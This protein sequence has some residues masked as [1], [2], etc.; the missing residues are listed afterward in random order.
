MSLLQLNFQGKSWSRR[1]CNSYD[2]WSTTRALKHRPGLP[3]Y[4]SPGWSARVRALTAHGVLTA[5]PTLTLPLTVSSVPK[6]CSPH[7]RGRQREP[8]RSGDVPQ[9]T[10]H[11]KTLSLLAFVHK[12]DTVSHGRGRCQMAALSVRLHVTDADAPARQGSVHPSRHV[13]HEGGAG[14]SRRSWRSTAHRRGQYQRT[15]CSSAGRTT[16]VLAQGRRRLPVSDE[17]LATYLI[18]FCAAR[19]ANHLSCAAVLPYPCARAAHHASCHT[20]LS[21]ASLVPQIRPSLQVPRR[22]G[23]QTPRPSWP[24]PHVRA[25]VHRERHISVQPGR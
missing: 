20:L 12:V 1:D 19:Y 21:L 15:T 24:R 17:V 16:G 14:D 3:L 9:L 11:P 2:G 23:P 5:M 8:W 10:G 7:L 22:P 6:R 4:H 13:R 25:L 18:R